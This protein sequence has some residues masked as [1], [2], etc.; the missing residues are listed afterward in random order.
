MDR[1]R[2]RMRSFFLASLGHAG[3]ALRPDRCG[4]ESAAHERGGLACL[5]GRRRDHRRTLAERVAPHV[6][7]LPGARFRCV[8]PLLL[9]SLSGVALGRQTQSRDRRNGGS[10]PV[11]PPR[12]SQQPPWSRRVGVNKA[13]GNCGGETEGQRGIR[14]VGLSRGPCVDC[15]WAPAPFF[16]RYRTDG[17]DGSRS[18]GWFPSAQTTEPGP[19]YSIPE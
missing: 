8:Q 4:D 19:A 16:V 11:D 9:P 2:A 18:N 3:A 7:H 15:R 12:R 5:P 10:D 13:P 6:P 17:R 1:G 14:N